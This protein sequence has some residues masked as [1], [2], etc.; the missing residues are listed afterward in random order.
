MMQGA[1]AGGWMLPSQGPRTLGHGTSVPANGDDASSASAFR[2]TWEGLGDAGRGQE[3]SAKGTEIETAEIEGAGANRHDPD[4]E[5]VVEPVLAHDED[6]LPSLQSH[7]PSGPDRAP[8]PSGRPLRDPESQARPAI[9]PHDSNVQHPTSQIEMAGGAGGDIWASAGVSAG[10]GPDQ[11]LSQHVTLARAIPSHTASPASVQAARVTGPGN[12]YGPVTAAAESGHALGA[13]DPPQPRKGRNDDKTE[14]SPRAIGAH[15]GLPLQPDIHTIG[16]AERLQVGLPVLAAET[17]AEPVKRSLGSSGER[18]SPDLPLLGTGEQ[19]G[20]A[21]QNLLSATA[22]DARTAQSAARQIAIA[23][24]RATDGKSEFTLSPAE[25]GRVRFGLQVIEGVVTVHIQT[26]RPETMDLLRRHIDGLFQEFRQQG[27]DGAT[28]TFGDD[29]QAPRDAA[30]DEGPDPA[31]AVTG[32]DVTT[33]ITLVP[34]LG[35]LD[36]RL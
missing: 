6:D 2:A 24:S 35:Q 27:F 15:V 25:L 19:T 23:V 3:P 20:K 11:P 21:V 34:S 14:P 31:A 12:G 33:R 10:P 1:I 7:G 26:E 30:P 36:L 29:R 8:D 17:A 4:P 18:A 16:V 13:Q 28:F 22:G 5:A 32:G 9:I